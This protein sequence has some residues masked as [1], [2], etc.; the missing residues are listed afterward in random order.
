MNRKNAHITFGIAFFHVCRPSWKFYFKILLFVVANVLIYISIFTVSKEKLLLISK[1]N[2]YDLCCFFFSSASFYRKRVRHIC[3]VYKWTKLHAR[4]HIGRVE[5]QRERKW[6][7]KTL[8]HKIYN[9]LFTSESITRLVKDSRCWRIFREK[10][11]Q[12]IFFYCYLPLRFGYLP[13]I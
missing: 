10:K 11:K 8:T 2:V 6:A 12:Q 4:T 13:R 1:Q 9:Y 3:T 5:R 7:R